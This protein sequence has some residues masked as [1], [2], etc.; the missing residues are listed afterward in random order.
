MRPV[1]AKLFDTYGDSLLREAEVY[2]E[3]ELSGLLDTMAVDQS[4]RL[5]LLN[6]FF[7]CYYR[8]SADAFAAGLHL[9][10]SLLHDEVRRTRPQER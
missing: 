9:G 2:D 5:D 6:A 7:D 3:K 10:L 1:Y 4:T 8:W